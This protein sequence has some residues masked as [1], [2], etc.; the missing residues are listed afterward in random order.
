MSALTGAMFN[1]SV[2]KH[3]ISQNLKKRQTLLQSRWNQKTKARSR[4]NTKKGLMLW[5]KYTKE[6]QSLCY[7]RQIL[8]SLQITAKPWYLERLPRSITSENWTI[9]PLMGFD[10]R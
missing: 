8:E 4:I 9:E 10:N 1:T 5:I 3:L 2:K 6:T 7:R